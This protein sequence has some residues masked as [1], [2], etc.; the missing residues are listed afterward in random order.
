MNEGK[1]TKYLDAAALPSLDWAEADAPVVELL[2]K[3]Y[4]VS[5]LIS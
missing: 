2:L 4:K 5:L 1:L 3:K